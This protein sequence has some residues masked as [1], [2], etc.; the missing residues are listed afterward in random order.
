VVVLLLC[1]AVPFGCARKRP[2]A[3]EVRLLPA[4][5]YAPDVPV[6]VDYALVDS[7][8][9][10]RATGVSRLY[11]R[12]VYEGRADKYAIRGFYREQMPLARWS[13]LS[14]GNVKGD[15]IM[16]FEKGS[17]SCMIM[18][19]DGSGFGH[20]ARIQVIIAREERGQTP[21]ATRTGS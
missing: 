10:D 6:P 4:R 18:I 8:S 12:H 21:P 14:D 16:R 9:E 3:R 15:I 19:S 11:L 7:A 2:D 5:P 20:G 13:M 1:S 17:E